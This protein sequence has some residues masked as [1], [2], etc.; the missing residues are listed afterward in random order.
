[1]KEEPLRF[2]THMPRV[3]LLPEALHRNT[4]CVTVFF[5]CFYVGQNRKCHIF[6]VFDFINH[7]KAVNEKYMEIELNVLISIC[8]KIKTL[9]KKKKEKD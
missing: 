3:S 4:F 8:K 5:K 9:Q 7:L 1:M 6:P 2:S